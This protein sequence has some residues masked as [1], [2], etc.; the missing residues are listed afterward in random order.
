MRKNI[1]SLLCVAG[2]SLGVGAQVYAQPKT[3]TTA[4]VTSPSRPAPELSWAE[5]MCSDLRLEMGTVARN[6]K[7]E[8][9]LT[10][11]NIYKEDVTI[12]GIHTTC[13]CFT[14]NP[15]STFVLKSHEVATISVDMDTV[16]FQGER[17]A[18]LDFT[19]TFDGSNF[20]S[21]RIPLHGFIRTDVELSPQLLNLGTMEEGRGTTRS[22]MVRFTRPGARVESVRSNNPALKAEVRPRSSN[23]YEIAVTV[24]PKTP[25]GVVQDLLTIVTNDATNRELSLSVSGKVEPDLVVTP[26]ALSL[27]NMRPGVD[28]TV[29]ITIRGQHPFTIE[30]LERDSALDVWKRKYSKDAKSLHVITLTMSPPETPG[31][32]TETFTVT[33]AG[34]PEPIRFT[35]SGNIISAAPAAETPKTADASNETKVEVAK[36]VA[37]ETP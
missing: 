15:K 19:A 26:K 16:R 22:A 5:K 8:K 11:K 24:D 10:I 12:Q 13:G 9:T 33:V 6:T 30:K 37:T 23:E 32:Y 21:V 17:N 25:L 4:I 27:G 2:S 31:A 29:N 7:I 35:A 34:R 18:N 14:P 1:L 20:K 3:T 36:P 28:K